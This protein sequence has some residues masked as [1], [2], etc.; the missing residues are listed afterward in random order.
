M[1]DIG[2]DIGAMVAMVDAETVGTELHLRSEHDPPISIHTG[3]WERQQGT[4]T[5]YA[6]VFAELREGAYWVLDDRGDDVRRVEV[7][8]GE[9]AQIDLRT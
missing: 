7:T 5:V 3:V 4:E 8:G 2:G 1:I 6:A 9:V